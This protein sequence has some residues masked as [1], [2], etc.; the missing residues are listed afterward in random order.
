MSLTAEIPF[1]PKASHTSG[2]LL[3]L[4]TQPQGHRLHGAI[5][6]LSYKSLHGHLIWAYN[7]SYEKFIC[8]G[9]A[10]HHAHL[11]QSI[12]VTPVFCISHDSRDIQYK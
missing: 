11:S 9:K 3:T 7:S 4:K 1:S 12:L 10:K 6:A 2:N 5:L 8:S